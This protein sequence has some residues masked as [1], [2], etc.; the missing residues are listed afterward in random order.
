MS[1]FKVNADEYWGWDMDLDYPT[2]YQMETINECG[3]YGA[4]L[5]K[6]GFFRADNQSNLVEY[7]FWRH[8]GKGN[9]RPVVV[10][11]LCEY[12]EK[13]QIKKFDQFIFCT[14]TER[15]IAHVEA[16]KLSEKNLNLKRIDLFE[17]SSNFY[18]G[19]RDGHQTISWGT[20]YVGSRFGYGLVHFGNSEKSGVYTTSYNINTSEVD[21]WVIHFSSKERQYQLDESC[22]SANQQVKKPIFKYTS[23]RKDLRIAADFIGNYDELFLASK[24]C[25]DRLPNEASI[26]EAYLNNYEEQYG[27]LYK[28]L[29]AKL[30]LVL[31]EVRNEKILS[32]Y[33]NLH[34]YDWFLRNVKNLKK[35]QDQSA[36]CKKYVLD[37]GVKDH[38]YMPNIS[39]A[40]YLLRK[41]NK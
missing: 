29:S 20:S 31:S 36:A 16:N 27:A 5:F 10:S 9:E 8:F 7:G 18:I 6:N 28:D 32:Y 17:P 33:Q 37:A 3:G 12:D 39:E 19:P 4:P 14:S 23:L 40:S 13:D 1:A 24:F 35:G 15:L 41:W 34:Y 30:P 2:Y 21:H 22:P 11:W 26:Y 25:S 38:W